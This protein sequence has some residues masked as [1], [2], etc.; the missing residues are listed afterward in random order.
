MGRYVFQTVTFPLCEAAAA[1]GN[2]ASYWSLAGKRISSKCKGVSFLKPFQRLSWDISSKTNRVFGHIATYLIT[3]CVH[4]MLPC[5]DNYPGSLVKEMV[6][7]SAIFD[8]AD[9]LRV[10]SE[11]SS[12]FDIPVP[13]LFHCLFICITSSLSFCQ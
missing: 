11:V 13:F 1:S 2:I 5:L 4:T 7:A 6:R 9:M 10:D 3:D 12:S 8:S